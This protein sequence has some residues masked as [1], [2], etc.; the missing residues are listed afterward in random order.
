MT[1]FVLIQRE[2]NEGVFFIMKIFVV[3]LAQKGEQITT[4]TK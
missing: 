4:R 1:D 3:S 2:C